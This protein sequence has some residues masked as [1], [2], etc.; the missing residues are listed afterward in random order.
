MFTGNEIGRR[1]YDIRKNLKLT[2]DEFGR[3]YD[4]SGPAV[5]K[6]EKGKV[7]P[8]LELWLRIAKDMGMPESRAVL[9]WAREK[10][11]EKYR[12]YI[13]INAMLHEDESEYAGKGRADYL[14][15]RDVKQLRKAAA[16]DPSL[17]AG[18]KELLE[19]DELWALYQP[20]GQEL[21]ALKKM[22]GGLGGGRKE[23]FRAAL[24]LV[25]DFSRS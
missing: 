12:E 11:P 25:R 15:I 18:L 24:H 6:F 5:F 1:I 23:Q 14:N 7:K 19:D 8:S 22:F 13:D 21:H 4:I 10:L 17:P 3:R 16:E 9:I 2:Q 20:T